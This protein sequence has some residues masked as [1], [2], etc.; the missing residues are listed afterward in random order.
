MVLALPCAL[1]YPF[2]LV[3]TLAASDQ[4][5][6]NK[7]LTKP[8]VLEYFFDLLSAHKP[9]ALYRGLPVQLASSLMYSLA[10]NTSYQCMG[11]GKTLNSERCARKVVYGVCLISLCLELL[12]YPLDTYKKFVQLSRAG[13]YTLPTCLSQRTKDIYHILRASYPGLGFH[14]ARWAVMAALVGPI[15]NL[16]YQL[17]T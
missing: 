1:S 17:L 10:I 15:G 4:S 13:K 8:N 9:S 11:K 12:L 16:F 3:H 6:A 14:L 2:D 5:V 7:I